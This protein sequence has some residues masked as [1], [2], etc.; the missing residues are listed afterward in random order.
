MLEVIVMKKAT[1]VVLLII[2]VFV[3]SFLNACQI[4]DMGKSGQDD[5]GNIEDV[6]GDPDSPFTNMEGLGE[7]I[8]DKSEEEIPEVQEPVMVTEEGLVCLP[9]DLAEEK[10]IITP[11]VGEGGVIVEDVITETP[12]EEKEKEVPEEKEEEEEPVETEPTPDIPKGDLPIVEFNEGDLAT[13]ENFR[14]V[15]ADGDVLTHTYSNHFS[16][17]GTWQTSIGDAGEYTIIIT[18]S[19]GKDSVSQGVKVIIHSV[20]DAPVIDGPAEIAVDEGE[21]VVLDFTITDPNRDEVEVAYS[22]WM[23][24]NTYE[25]T[26]DDAGEHS[27]TITASDGMKQSSAEVKVTV[28]NVNRVP[29][30]EGIDDITVTEGD[31]VDAD[32]VA[33]D[34][35]RDAVVYTFSEPLNENGEWQTEDG[36]AGVYD[37]IVTVSDGETETSDSFTLTV[38]EFNAEPVME[39]IEDITVNEGEIVAFSPV[40]SDPDRDELE[41]IYTGWMAEASYQTT[42][43]DAGEYVVTVTVSDGFYDISQEV[44]VTVND[45]NRPPVFAWG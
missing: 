29:V 27:V 25:T 11:D 14:A 35:D 33:S 3:L 8:E 18:A 21:T 44:T 19:D 39:H 9:K 6:L 24:S 41:I 22:G 5:F 31:A 20:N 37:I 42:Y 32:V 4:P 28:N 36:D 15:D 12:E 38:D 30:I 45:V 7:I 1:L 34:P 17:D 26:F 40:A 13:L 2:S 43:D 10:G 23:H 16:E